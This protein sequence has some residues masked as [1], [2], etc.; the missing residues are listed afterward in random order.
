[1]QALRDSAQRLVAQG[2]LPGARDA[3]ERVLAALPEDAD[4]LLQLSYI[5]SLAGH[6][7]AAHAHALRAHAANPSNPG[8]VAELA[9]RLRT[10]NE[11]EL[12]FECTARYVAAGASDLPVLLALAV[13]LGNVNEYERAL[14]LASI[15]LA[16]DPALVP[17]LAVRS[18]FLTFLGRF[19]EARAD[20]AECLRLA[21]GNPQ[22]HWLL[23]R[24][25]KAKAGDH[26]VP[27]I[28]ARL[29]RSA[30]DPGDRTLLAYALHKELDDLGDFNG[31]A[32]ALAQAC[33]A[34]RS[35]LR[36]A[37][38]QS[39]ALV[40]ALVAWS[41][42]SQVRA[43]MPAAGTG[44]IPVFIV[45]MHR[46][47]T[48]LL[49]Q[50]LSAHGDVR[51]IGELY[52][53]TSQMREAADHHCRGVIDLEMVRRAGNVDFAAVGAGYLD[54]LEWRLGGERWFTDK[55][56]SN[57]LNAG[58]ICRALPQARILHMV[59]DPVETCF[60]NLRELFSDVN[61]WSYDQREL[62]HYYRQYRRLMAHWH[63]ALPGRIMDVGYADLVTAPEETMRRV[64]AF[65]GL[66]FEN[67]MLDPSA[68]G[69]AVGT[70]S[71]V[72]VRDGIV[73]RETPKWVAYAQYLQPMIGALR[74]L[75]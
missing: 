10:F 66:G 19:D 48:T 59:R 75:S 61:P 30:R 35:Q 18:N 60:S 68:N 63:E 15:A 14:A 2:D 38:E 71:A 70:A 53:F 22:A 26:E 9:A 56:P 8:Q 50:L 45:G 11:I 20:L 33:S 73:V 39:E 3:Y 58:F 46:S 43:A 29:A 72:Q 51:G 52:D 64:A 34:K 37:P 16:R 21:P 47:G 28:R 27:A 40:D 25:R 17:A 36:Y 65:C 4:A 67:D 41:R 7:R 62:A 57:F 44:R 32:R 5:E 69:R 24:L 55:L 42:G 74:D 49:E 54:K 13:H 6:Y 23:A 31:A 1:M 12:L